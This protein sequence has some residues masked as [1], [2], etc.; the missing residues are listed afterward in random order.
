VG[1][2]QE[3]LKPF[4]P[5]TPSIAR[6]WD[7]WLGG[8]DNFVADRQLAQKMLAINPLARSAPPTRPRPCTS[9]P[10]TRSWPSSTAWNWYRQA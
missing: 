5:G 1:V 10:P 9:T 7:Y 8:K 4:D 2:R 3:D 6:V